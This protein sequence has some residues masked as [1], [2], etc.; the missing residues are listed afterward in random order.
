MKLEILRSSLKQ[1]KKNLDRLEKI[2]NPSEKVKKGIKTSKNTFSHKMELLRQREDAPEYKPHDWANADNDYGFGD[3]RKYI[4]SPEWAFRKEEYYKFHKKVCRS[5]RSE[6]REIHLHHRTYA[7]IY[8]ED[9]GDLMPLCK[10]CHASLHYLQKKIGVTVEE[11]SKLWLSATLANP[12]RKKISKSLRSRGFDDFRGALDKRFDP[13]KS[14]QENLSAAIDW[15]RT[16]H[17]RPKD[18]V[19]KD[20]ARLKAEISY[21]RRTGDAKSYDKKVD[22]LMRRLARS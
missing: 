17:L 12:R 1:V 6:D 19:I 15:M 3:Y 9:D 21:V 2:K 5:C 16:S 4:N 11:A 14:G 8:R 7:R 13:Q 22:R 10:D 20:P 18:S